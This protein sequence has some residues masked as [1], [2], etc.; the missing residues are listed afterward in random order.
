MKTSYQ[1]QQTNASLAQFKD[2]ATKLSNALTDVGFIKTDDTGQLNINSIEAVPG[3]NTYAGYEIRKLN[4]SLY[5][6]SPIVMKI[7]YGTGSASTYPAL[8][9]TVGKTTDGAGNLTGQFLNPQVLSGQYLNTTLD[10]YVSCGEGYVS[11]ALFVGGA[12]PFGAY[13]ARTC[14]PTTGTPNDNG[15]HLV[16]DAGSG[17]FFQQGMTKEGGR[18]PYQNMT[19]PCCAAP[20]A[21]NGSYGENVGVYPIFHFLGYPYGPDF[22]GCG[23]FTVD[24]GTG[25]TILTLPVNGVSRTFVCL[26]GNNT[27]YSNRINGNTN[28]VGAIMMRWE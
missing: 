24:I 12:Y 28:V 11:F 3:S 20:V 18:I 26:S 27:N 10:S 4:D 6:T 21:G 22:V 2:W 25:G 7:E 8:R 9:I 23:Y 16:I 19:S 15:F 5:A 13:I 1:S 17:G 14:N